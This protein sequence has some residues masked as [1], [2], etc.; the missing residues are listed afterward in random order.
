MALQDGDDHDRLS[1]ALEPPSEGQSSDKLMV[2]LAAL[3][4]QLEK[5]VSDDQ[6]S[7]LVRQK[8]GVLDAISKDPSII[9]PYLSCNEDEWMAA[10][11][12]GGVVMSSNV[13]KLA[14]LV[15]K[16]LH[17]D[18]SK[19]L[20]LTTEQQN[21][22][23][24]V[25]SNP[26]NVSQ[27]FTAVNTPAPCSF[28]LPQIV[29]SCMNREDLPADLLKG[30][31]EAVDSGYKT[32]SVLPVN[33]SEKFVE[34][35]LGVELRQFLRVPDVDRRLTLKDVAASQGPATP[36]SR[37]DILV[38]VPLPGAEIERLGVGIVEFKHTSMSPMQALGQGLASAGNLA[39]AQL[40]LG[41]HHS[42]VAVPL[43]LTTAHF[44][45]FAFVT[46]LYHG[47]PVGNVLCNVMSIGTS[48]DNKEQRDLS[49]KY[50]VRYFLFSE[51][52]KDILR[53]ISTKPSL[54]TDIKF[55]LSLEIYD[56]K[57]CKDMF[58]KCDDINLSILHMWNLHE[59]AK[60]IDEIIKPLG[61]MQLKFPLKQKVVKSL[62]SSLLR[63]SLAGFE[64]G[65]NVIIFRNLQGY[66]LGL[67]KEATMRKDFIRR[68]KI[69]TMQLHSI[70][71]VHMGLHPYNIVWRDSNNGKDLQLRILNLETATKI[72][73]VI[74]SP[75][76]N[77]LESLYSWGDNAHTAEVKHDAW[78]IYVLTLISSENVEMMADKQAGDMM[79]VFKKTLDRMFG[80][81]SV[82]TRLERFE[83]WFST[84]WND[85]DVSLTEWGFCKEIVFERHVDLS[86]DNLRRTK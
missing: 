15:W 13:R 25:A 52:Q 86:D 20:V 2:L 47:L 81:V 54:M 60:D 32:F 76:R 75:L 23:K 63:G 66:K 55:G 4:L 56:F 14:L 28:N 31:A 1:A 57:L 71:I 53:K 21:A 9:E 39:I 84:S 7:H 43:L 80:K 70:G 18:E 3:S 67:P 35:K 59:M 33:K 37:P 64:S 8:D 65:V 26:K 38:A 50:L 10:I 19:M 41:L 83:K 82:T 27:M 62:S 40:K 46:L 49:I 16:A 74:T 51:Q 24:F 68:V 44:Y 17:P 61:V 69:V 6:Q 85:P 45:L 12:H 72:G 29:K 78:A 34:T 79:R 5:H 73:D 58:N 30:A 22:S 42:Q 11:S 77:S 48:T 36:D